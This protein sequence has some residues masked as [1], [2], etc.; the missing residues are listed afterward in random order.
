[1]AKV[2]LC[3]VLKASEF[4]FKESYL[5]YHPR[6]EVD[7]EDESL[8]WWFPYLTLNC[9]LHDILAGGITSRKSTVNVVQAKIWDVVVSVVFK[10][11]HQK[12]LVEAAD[13]V[14]SVVD[15]FAD[16]R[17]LAS[18]MLILVDKNVEEDS[19]WDVRGFD[20][21]ERLWTFFFT[22]NSGA[23]SNLWF[24]SSF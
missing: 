3:F 22:A 17:D 8:V 16:L 12:T 2:G 5:F 7:L 24:V 20:V 13:A 15:Y 6:Y 18:D 19:P 1:M 14:S 11:G 23:L 21:Q 10:P 9:D 4:G